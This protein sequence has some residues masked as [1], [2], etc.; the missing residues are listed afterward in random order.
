[1]NGMKRWA[2]LLLLGWSGEAAAAACTSNGAGNW[3]AAATWSC[4]H[5]PAAGDTVTI[6]SGHSITLNVNTGIL[7]SLTVNSGGTL[8]TAGTSGASIY[9]G[10]DLVNNG[11]INMQVSTGTNTIFL[12]GAGITSTFSGSGTWL[13]D[14]LDLN[15]GGGGTSCSGGCR[16]EVSGSPN[17]QFISASLFSGNSA[18]YT[19]NALGNATATV[20]LNRAGNQT[21]AATGVTYPNLVLG[22]TGTKTMG[23]GNGQTINVLGGLTVGSGVTLSESNRNPAVNVAGTVTNNGIYNAGAGAHVIGGFVNTGTY[24]GSA[25]AVTL[26]GNFSNSGLFT[27]GSGPWA[28]QGSAAQSITGSPAFQNL[29]MNNAA[30][31]TLAGGNVTV[32]TLLTLT[33][34]AIVTGGNTLIASG[35]NCATS[36]SRTAGYVYG[37]LQLTFPATSPVTC[38][39]HVGD[40]SNYAPITVTKTGANAGTLAATTMAGDHADTIA[41]TSGIYAARGVNRTWALSG[42]T[43]ASGTPY[44][45]VFQFCNAAGA[46]CGVNDVDA[47]AIAANFIV[48]QKTGAAWSW[49]AIGT[50]TGTAIQATGLNAFGAFAVGEPY[51]AVVPPGA[52]NAFETATAA[53]AVVGVIHTRMA[54]SA[55]SLDV[56]AVTAGAQASGFTDTVKVELLGNVATGIALDAQNCPASFTV[57]Q[58]V[59]PAPAIT[60][61]RSTVSFAAVPDAWRDVRLRISYPATAPT[62][63]SCSTDNFAIRPS[64][65]AVS[66]WDADW[67]TSGSARALDNAGAAGGNVHK[68]GQP[69]TISAAAYNAAAAITGN[70]QGSPS[71]QATACSQPA[72]ACANGTLTLGV[73][74]GSGTVSTSTAS[75]SEAGSF[76]LTLQD[77][78]FASVDAGD[79]TPADCTGY[80]LCSAAVAVG[81]FVPDHFAVAPG[82]MPQ[83]KT[84]NSTACAARPFTYIGQPFGY[85]IPPQ[86]LVIAQN[87]ANATTTNY[88]GNLWKIATAPGAPDCMTNPDVCTL[89]SG[90]VLQSYAYS[91]SSGALPG[92]DSTQVALGT[93]NVAA[94]ND[95]T[96]TVIGASGDLLAFLRSQA[97]PQAP[98]AASITLTESVTDSSE[99]GCGTANCE[100]NTLVPLAF[101]PVA[102]DAGNE[103]R[104]GRLKLSNAYG[105]QVLALPVPMLAQYWNGAA[106]VANAADDCTAIPAGNVALAPS[107][108]VTSPA[109]NNPFVKGDGGLR[110]SAPN[111]SGYADITVMAPPYLQGAWTGAA[112]NQNPAARAT[113]GIYKGSSNFIFQREDY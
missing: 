7:A 75:Y 93:P 46:D 44:S 15:G 40:A 99:T 57:L 4:G 51:P 28:F 21:V 9:L 78:A 39:F 13:L 112:Y 2:V 105:S 55:F 53:G 94:N 31:L 5:V 56:V 107:G 33:S 109:W 50:R 76:N 97:A 30:G 111:A 96:G 59:S 47:G 92:W 90:S 36:V 68:A 3:G 43:L 52:F 12:S 110:L 54:G 22:G 60:G 88:R 67:A 58:T 103:F 66:A 6:L 80:Y 20:T 83:L 29:Q 63:S 34:G 10:G 11:T 17:L 101:S 79:G 27:S 73:W 8:T 85:V 70:Y 71:V 84:F 18:T 49:P 32:S 104:Y 95:G 87:A 102:F 106:F 91:T 64:M 19:F 35:A 81:R 65:L 72:P 38:V 45:A 24:R 16:V 69:F 1:M 48:A 108:I 37:N 113:F 77:T 89:V 86:V 26:A 41:G 42:G 61:G 82:N 100:I 23:T 98:F 62:V 74:S 14:N 25:G